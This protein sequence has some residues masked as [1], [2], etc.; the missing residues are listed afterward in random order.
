MGWLA[1]AAGGAVRGSFRAAGRT[2][3]RHVVPDTLIPSWQTQRTFS[4]LASG[5][6]RGI[7]KLARTA[8]RKVARKGPGLLRQAWER[9]VRPGLQ[10]VASLRFRGAP[11]TAKESNSPART[12]PTTASPRAGQNHLSEKRRDLQSGPRSIRAKSKATNLRKYVADY[13]PQHLSQSPRLSDADKLRGT[14]YANFSNAQAAIASGRYAT[15]ADKP[16]KNAWANGDNVPRA[17]EFDP[18]PEYGPWPKRAPTRSKHDQLRAGR[19][20]LVRSRTAK[21]TAKRTAWRRSLWTE[22]HF[23]LQGFRNARR[24]QAAA[25]PPPTR[26]RFKLW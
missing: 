3:S 8:T 21:P 25:T 22:D 13:E 9:E 18:V 16:S 19:S 1:R 4:R 20:R 10:T 12:A 26:S 23:A 5:T 6:S 15:P 24:E 11:L 7:S 14:A 2:L 17:S